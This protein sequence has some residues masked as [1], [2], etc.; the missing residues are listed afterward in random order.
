[1]KYKVGNDVWGRDW[2]IVNIKTNRDLIA[3]METYNY[4]EPVLDEDELDDED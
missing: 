4:V 3:Y 1:M 2:E